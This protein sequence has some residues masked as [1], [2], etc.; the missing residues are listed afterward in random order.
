MPVPPGTLLVPGVIAVHQVDPAG[1]GLDPVHDAGQL[2]AAGV[3][4]AGIQAEADVVV[5]AAGDRLPEPGHRVQAAG[6]RAVAARRVL[7]QHRHR[8]LDSLD[9]LLPVLVPLLGF[10]PRVHV[11]AVHDHARCADGGGGLQVLPEQLAAGNP[12]PVVGGRHVDPVRSVD[13][14]LDPRLGERFPQR[15]RLTGEG[16]RLPVLRVA[17][18][19]LGDFRFPGGSGG[20]RVAAVHVGPDPRHPPSLEASGASCA[21][22]GRPGAAASRGRPGAPHRPR[23][24]HAPSVTRQGGRAPARRVRR[25]SRRARSRGP[26]RRTRL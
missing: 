3:R 17:E 19:E 22:A 4:V 7:D 26:R 11:A 13:E 8:A 24:R 18:K 25:R 20:E 23:C 2:L 6:H 12:D 15:G 1:D 21:A 16:R 14:D 5:E 10:G 9:R